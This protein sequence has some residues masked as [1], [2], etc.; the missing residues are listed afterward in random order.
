MTGM[1]GMAGTT[2][3]IG[4][5]EIT[6]IMRIAKMTW[7]W[8]VSSEAICIVWYKYID[9]ENLQALYFYIHAS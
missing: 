4:M 9:I 8:D 3:I 2:R 1:N 7:I 6:K 5:T